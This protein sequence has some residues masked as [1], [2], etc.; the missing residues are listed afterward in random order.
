[1][2]Q[3]RG[4]RSV[5]ILSPLVISTLRQERTAYFAGNRSEAGRDLLIASY[6]IHKCFGLDGR[7][8]PRRTMTVIKEIG[9]DIMALQEVDRRFGNRAGLLDLHEL[10]QE[11]G[12]VPI[13]LKGAR[14]NHGWHGNLVLVRDGTVTTAR[15]LVL[16]GGEP[17]GALIIDVVLRGGPLRIIA[18]H[19]GLIRRSRARQ[20]KTILAAA[21]TDDER[22][23]LLMGD[24]NEW[25][26][27]RRS[28]L[29]ALEPVCRL[30]FDARCRFQKT[31]NLIG[32]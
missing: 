18:A 17:R 15:Q 16:T 24:L 4:R 9:A 8:N 6:N 20:I 30:V 5:K 29:R 2:R 27:G 11:S 23:T 32:A 26:L 14:N 21:E 19:L 31:R 25:R 28:T 12:L 22:P 10:E 1:M 13:R 7:F 3:R